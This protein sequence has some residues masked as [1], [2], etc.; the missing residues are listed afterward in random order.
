MEHLQNGLQRRERARNG[1][2]VQLGVVLRDFIDEQV[3]PR[4]TRFAPLAEVWQQL[5]PQAL[6]GHS[7]IINLENGQL[8]VAVD[9]AVYA[10]ELKMCSNELVEELSEQCPAARVNK[11]KVVVSG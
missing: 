4:Y 10:Y 11:I 9:L 6:A 8:T 7:R 2:A 3:G 1:P 5:L